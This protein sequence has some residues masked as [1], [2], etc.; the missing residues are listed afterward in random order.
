MLIKI[1]CPAVALV[2]SRL[3]EVG[4]RSSPGTSEMELLVEWRF[5]DRL[6]YKT[7]CMI[8]VQLG[9]AHRLSNGDLT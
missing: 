4:H 1:E 5:A 8:R 2:S 3:R 7:K 6:C 9:A